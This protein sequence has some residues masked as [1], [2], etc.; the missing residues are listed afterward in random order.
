MWAVLIQWLLIPDTDNNCKCFVQNYITIVT[1]DNKLKLKVKRLSFNFH[2]TAAFM[3]HIYIYIFFLIPLQAWMGPVGSRRLRL[4]DFKTIGTRRWQG[5]QPY[6]LATFTPQEIFLALIS[7]RGWVNPRTIVRPV[8]LCQWKISVTLSG[9]KPAT[10]WF[11]AQCLNQL[12]HCVPPIHD[13]IIRY[14]MFYF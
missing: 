9:I 10:F 5:C 13:I 11:V 2:S 14:W 1:I 3:I 6:A 8:G 12:C 7:V 4:P